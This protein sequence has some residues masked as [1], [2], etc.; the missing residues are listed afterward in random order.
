MVSK[1]FSNI[2]LSIIPIVSFAQIQNPLK[3]GTDIAQFVNMILGYVVR[4][5]GIAAIFAFIYVG[6]LFVKAKGNESEL[7][8]AKNTFF[9]TVI[10]VAI[11]LGAQIISTIITGT[12]RGLQ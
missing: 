8:K 6:F 7:T 9:N 12:I 10:G 11:L 4:I 1:I 5:G 2:A 3:G